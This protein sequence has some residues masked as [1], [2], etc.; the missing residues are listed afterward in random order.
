MLYVVATPI[1]NLSDI[2]FRA[3]ETLKSC[4][5]LLCEDT[6][7]SGIL[8]HHYDIHKPL[9]SF[10]KFSEASKQQ[11][12][13]EDL[14]KGM[15][16]GVISDAGTPGI[17]DPGEKLIQECVRQEISVTVIPGA[18]AAIAALCCS[19][20]TTERFQFVGFLPR[21]A[22]ELKRFLQEIL[23]Y[24][25]TTIC[26]ES[27]NR[28][29]DV[30][31]ALQALAPDRQLVV[32]R[33]LTKKFEEVKRGT[34]SDLLAYWSDHVLKGEIVLLVSAARD[35]EIQDWMSLTP[36]Q[37]VEFIQETYGVSRQEAVVHAA[38]IRGV[39]KREVYNAVNRNPLPKKEDGL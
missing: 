9:K 30:L 17:A 22:G 13:I 5:Y 8:L 18:C 25:G 3:V 34:A 23:A 12:V 11:E 35:P 28:L 6:R 33:E 15:T 27:P 26:Y 16:I 32:A 4:D 10:H 39:S 1:G 36:Q 21:K 20:L 37:H 24:T 7:H 31:E 38:K 2:T 14:Q 19:G 29:S